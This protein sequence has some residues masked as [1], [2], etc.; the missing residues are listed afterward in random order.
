MTKERKTGEEMGLNHLH[1][2]VRNLY[3]TLHFYESYFRFR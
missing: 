3:R 2:H 1:L